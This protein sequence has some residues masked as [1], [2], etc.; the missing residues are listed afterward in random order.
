MSSY[1]H[2]AVEV[3]YYLGLNTFCDINEAFV[4]MFST[5][6]GETYQKYSNIFKLWSISSPSYLICASSKK[7]P[8]HILHMYQVT[9]VFASTI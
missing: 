6:R 4:E 2:N 1:T 5:K 8:T 9:Y 3:I 7:Q